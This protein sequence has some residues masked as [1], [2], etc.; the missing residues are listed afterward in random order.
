MQRNVH[1]SFVYIMLMIAITT[2]AQNEEKQN[3]GSI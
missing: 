3:P 1:N 2:E